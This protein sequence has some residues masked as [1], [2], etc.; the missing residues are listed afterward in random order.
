[1][2]EAKLAKVQ[3]ELKIFKG[4]ATKAI[5]ELESKFNEAEDEGDP[6]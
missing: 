2:L 3:E 5:I 4:A 1:M 6:L